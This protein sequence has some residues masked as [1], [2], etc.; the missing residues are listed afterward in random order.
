MANIKCQLNSYVETMA[1]AL[2]VE[3]QFLSLCRVLVPFPT[4]SKHAL[5]IVWYCDL[6]WAVGSLIP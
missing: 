5:L 1:F 6:A 3:L 4:V 2:R